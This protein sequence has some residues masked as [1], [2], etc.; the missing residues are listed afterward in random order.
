ML[1]SSAADQHAVADPRSPPAQAEQDVSRPSQDA[2]FR[3][4]IV[5]RQRLL[6]RIPSGPVSPPELRTGSP[7]GPSGHASL[8]EPRTD[9]PSVRSARSKWSDWSDWSV[10]PDLSAPESPED[11]L[12]PHIDP[13]GDVIF[14]DK[15]R[16]LQ[17]LT[18]DGLHNEMVTDTS[19]KTGP[20]LDPK[21][22]TPRVPGRQ[23]RKA[24][25]SI[26]Y[27]FRQELAYLVR[28]CP[29]EDVLEEIKRFR[30]WKRHLGTWWDRLSRGLLPLSRIE[31]GGLRKLLLHQST[32][33]MK[34]AWDSNPLESR[35]RRWPHIMLSTLSS[36]P[37]RAKDVFAATFDASV[38]SGYMA[39]D[40]IHA[41][42]RQQSAGLLVRGYTPS[43]EDIAR[44]LTQ[45]LET[46]PPGYLRLRQRRIA[47]LIS[48]LGLD[49]A[50]SLYH[51]LVAYG[52]PLHRN[53]Q[54]HF[55]SSLAKDP[56]YKSLSV[57]ILRSLLGEG[58]LDINSPQGASLCTSILSMPEKDVEDDGEQN[59]ASRTQDLFEQLIQCGLNPNIIT[60]STIIRNL[61]LAGELDTA[62]DVFNILRER[63]IEPDAH[64]YSMLLNA[65]KLWR[66]SSSLRQVMDEVVLDEKVHGNAIIWTDLLHA[67]LLAGLRSGERYGK[68][69]PAP[70]STLAPSFPLM[71]QAY[72]KLFSMD[73]LKVLL[74]NVEHQMAPSEEEDAIFAASE[75]HSAFIPIIQG[76]PHLSQTRPIDPPPETLAIMLVGYM[77]ALSQPYE[78]IAFY[79]RFRNLLAENNHV[80]AELVQKQGTLVFDI[81]INSLCAWPGMLRVAL[82]VVYDMLKEA[83][84]AAAAAAAAASAA[85]S[86]LSTSDRD[87]TIGHL[88]KPSVYTWSIILHGFMKQGQSKHGETVLLMMRRRDITPNMV[89]WNTL[90]AGYARMQDVRGTVTA[91]QRLERAGFVADEYTF[92]AFGNLHDKDGALEHMEAMIARKELK[93]QQEIES[94]KDEEASLRGLQEE[95]DSLA[96]GL[97]EASLEE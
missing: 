18:E 30:K 93:R 90:A 53:T 33:A 4:Y 29:P 60:Y 82:D 19:F 77:R 48:T 83:T 9:S 71:L 84:A 62:W 2:S 78:I 20:L 55:A 22:T 37:D 45:V 73:A 43:A 13:T 10:W 97:E 5:P 79:E 12:D 3:K 76:L 96:H 85:S 49:Q 58:G 75:L 95:V 21:A 69:R 51:A 39:R 94:A 63:K 1:I 31:I 35:R 34:A 74:P 88:V 72:G 15:F 47:K 65:S 24:E 68:K 14:G 66:N 54:L 6:R 23:E 44:L 36:H 86:T 87:K 25:D 41:L 27:V 52:H 56:A 91:L 57:D 89:T 81:V 38:I 26:N 80:A 61:C 64:V 7:S 17:E 32:D 40:V 28:S 11:G 16:R 67:I 59:L 42:C 92:K 46:S 50:A 8:P 70:K